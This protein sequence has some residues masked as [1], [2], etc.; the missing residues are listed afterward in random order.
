MVHYPFIYLCYACV[1][2]KELTFG[3]SLPGALAVVI[4]S[5]ILAYVL[6]RCYDIPVRN[7]LVKRFLKK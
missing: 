2:N 3:Q 7:Y 4:G 5:M 6:L 1:K